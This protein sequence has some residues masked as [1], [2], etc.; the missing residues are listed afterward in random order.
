M[1]LIGLKCSY[2]EGLRIWEAG[3]LQLQFAGMAP[4]FLLLER[5]SEE[6][7]L[8]LVEMGIWRDLGVWSE[9]AVQDQQHS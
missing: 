3:P 2:T 7:N 6:W 1:W 4:F 5:I 9:K 8:V